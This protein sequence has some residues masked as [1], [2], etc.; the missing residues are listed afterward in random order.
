MPGAAGS[1]LDQPCSPDSAVI[2]HCPNYLCIDCTTLCDS[3][4]MANYPGCFGY[5]QS[6]DS[7]TKTERVREFVSQSHK[8]NLKLVKRNDKKRKTVF[9]GHSVLCYDI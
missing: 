9:I 6:P 8:I 4:V 7:A 5:F 3:D 2:H 1:V